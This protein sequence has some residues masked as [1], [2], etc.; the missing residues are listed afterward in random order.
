MQ[1]V[2]FNERMAKYGSNMEAYFRSIKK[3]KLENF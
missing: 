3:R 1:M 2:E